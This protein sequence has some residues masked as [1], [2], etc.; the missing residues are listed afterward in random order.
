MTGWEDL[1]DRLEERDTGSWRL[2]VHHPLAG[3]RID[4]HLMADLDSDVLDDHVRAGLDRLMALGPDRLPG[5]RS[6]LYSHAR[7]TIEVTDYGLP[8]MPRGAGRTE[9]HLRAFGVGSEAECFDPAWVTGGSVLGEADHALATLWIRPPWEV[10]HGANL[11][12]APDG[13]LSLDD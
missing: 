4:I 3:R 8:D 5:I 13:R 11:R 2:N 12:I 7:V 9:A 10:E 6:I 1:I